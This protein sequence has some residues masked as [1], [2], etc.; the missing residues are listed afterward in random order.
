MVD[1]QGIKIAYLLIFVFSF[2]LA[3]SGCVKQKTAGVV[4]DDDWENQVLYAREC[5]MDGLPC[6]ANKDQ[7]C[8][9]TQQ[10]CVDPNN[11]DRNHCKDECGCGSEGA[12]CCADDLPCRDGLACFAGYCVECGGISDPCCDIGQACVGD[13]VCN[14]EICAVCGLPGNPC[15]TAGIACKNQEK[16]DVIRTE[17]RDGVCIYCGSNGK[18]SCQFEPIC[19][20][21][22]LLNNNFCHPCGK[23]NQPC[24]NESSGVEYDCDLKSELICEL[25]FCTKK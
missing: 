2:G 5:G 9:Y 1:K 3:I 16:R 12:F 8:L 14:K 7:P 6:C 19:A 21:A 18:I 22:H 13:L 15:C 20:P 25:G 24:C 17:C 10:C 11:S 23:A 4:G